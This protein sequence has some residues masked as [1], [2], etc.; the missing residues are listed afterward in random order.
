MNL[1]RIGIAIFLLVVC[2][3]VGAAVRAT[4]DHDHV[5]LGDSVTLTIESDASDAQPDLA[6]L[7]VDFDVQGTSTGSQT[8]MV[9]GNVQSS[10]QWAVTL[11]PR[12]S[13]VI[14]IPALAVGHERTA[15]LR[16]EVSAQPVAQTTTQSAAS[17]ANGAPVFIET[18]I[19]PPNAYVQQALVYTVR[20]Y[21]AVTLL[22]G[23]LD[24]PV[25]DNGD[26]RQLGDDITTSAMVQGRRYNV[27]ERHYLLQPERSGALHIPAPGFRG[28]AMSDSI[29]GMFDD[30]TFGRGGGVHAIGKPLDAQVRARPPQAGDPWLPARAIALDVESSNAPLH[31]G[32]P[33]GIVV[34]LSGEGVTAAQLPEI[35]LPTIAGA[36]VYPEPS[37]TTEHQRDGRLQAERTRRFAIV[38]ERAG[39]LRL[40]ELTMP[41]WD[42]V[43]DHAALARHALPAMQVLP[44]I[45]M[46]TDTN[47]HPSSSTDSAN[48]A[49]AATSDSSVSASALRGWRIATASL[50]VLLAL[51]LWWGW[52]RGQ[53]EVVPIA[54]DRDAI[55]RTPNRAPTLSRALALGDPPAIAQALLEAAPGAPSRN[56]GEVALRLG[57]AAQRDA[58]LAFDAARWSADGAPSAQAL[59][60]L[61]EALKQPPRWIGRTSST[62]GDDALPPLYPS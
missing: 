52:R 8:S 54:Y 27:L 38:P 33:F 12:K 28:R 62:S 32:E 5:M 56:L 29:G 10:M 19:D 13:G 48:G 16:V 17:A 20:L 41:W 55:A 30:S 43:N 47:T 40:P 1:L 2:A 21:Y 3:H 49:S 46:Q 18:A 39:S 6:P 23:A 25:P 60:R 7:R 58:V 35:A 61:R 44:A 4:L 51:T 36:Q 14:D 31:A 57:D 37:S 11:A 50:A 42:V 45:A 34:K 24:A 53:R 26:L 15:P 9:N 22:D 59:A